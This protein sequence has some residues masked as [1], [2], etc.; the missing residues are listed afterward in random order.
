MEKAGPSARRVVE[1][2]KGLVPIEALRAEIRAEMG[3]G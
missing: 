1:T 3:A 2:D